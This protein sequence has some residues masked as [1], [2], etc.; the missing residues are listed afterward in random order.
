MSVWLVKN[1]SLGTT[2]KEAGAAQRCHSPSTGCCNEEQR[3]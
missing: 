2:A 1:S 3:S